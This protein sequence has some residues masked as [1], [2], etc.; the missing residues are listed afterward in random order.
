MGVY[1]RLVVSTGPFANLLSLLACFRHSFIRPAY[2]EKINPASHRKTLLFSRAMSDT[3]VSLPR[4]QKILNTFEFEYLRS[5]EGTRAVVQPF[6]K[7][8]GPRSTDLDFL[9]RNDNKTEFTLY[10]YGYTYLAGLSDC[11]CARQ[12][13]PVFK[14]R[15]ACSPGEFIRYGV[16]HT[17]QMTNRTIMNMRKKGN[18]AYS[19]D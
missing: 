2:Q 19:K 18:H 15:S 3:K 13:A 14:I 6:V 4:T 7:I 17:G 12:T 9:R 8:I 11:I 10:R 5:L 1:L 16:S